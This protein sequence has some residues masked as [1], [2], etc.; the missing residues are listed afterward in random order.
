MG[1]AKEK[2]LAWAQ[3]HGLDAQ[4]TGRYF[5][6]RENLFALGKI[7]LLTLVLLY[8]IL[9]LQFDH[10]LLPLAIMSAL[11]FGISGALW[12]VYISGASLNI[13]AAIG[14]V[15]VLG[16][17][18]DDP[19]LKVEVIRQLWADFRAK[20]YSEKLALEKAVESSGVICL[21][22]ML[23]TTLTTCLA[24]VP[25][26]FT[27]GIGSELQ[28]PLALVVIGGLTVGTFFTSWFIPLLFTA[29]VKK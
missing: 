14:L 22:P 29:I 16:I 12:L 1:S 10:V 21:K 15:V 6:S 13:M 4:F 26:F 27:S 18:I 17:I 7:F 25:V 3:H 2:I 11:A 5:E 28:R 9:A 19:I 23:M 8:F 24:L 20:G